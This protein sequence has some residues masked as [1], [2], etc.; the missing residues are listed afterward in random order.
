MA[1][2]FQLGWAPASGTALVDHLA[3]QGFGPGELVAAGLARPRE[4]GG[5]VFDLFRGRLM[6]PIHDPRGHAIGFGA[7]T[8]DPGGIPKYLN[9]PQSPIFDKGH[10]LFGLHRAARAIRAG[11]LAVVVEGYTDVI[12]AHAAGFDNV[13]ASL[14]TALTEHQVKLLK[15]FAG[16][17]VLALDAD[18]AGQAAT[19][20]GLEVAR[21]AAAG[22]VLPVP[23]A[24][25]MVRYEQRL[26]VELRVAALPTGRDPDD[27]IRT[28]PEAWR[29]AVAAA[30]PLMAYLFDALTADLDLADPRGRLKAADRLI[31]VIADIPDVVGRSVWLARL[32]ALIQIDE[33]DL[34]ARLPRVG[35]A[36]SAGGR[37]PADPRRRS[38]AAQ[39]G[40]RSPSSM[41]SRPARMGDDG[42]GRRAGGRRAGLVAPRE[43]GGDSEGGGVRGGHARD[44]AADAD[45]AGLVDGGVGES[46]GVDGGV[47]GDGVDATI[48]GDAD[49]TDV[50]APSPPDWAVEDVPLDLAD[51]GGLPPETSPADEP[52]DRAAARGTAGG[53][54]RARPAPGSPPPA[55][56]P[57]PAPGAPPRDTVP[58]WLLGMLLVDPRRLRAL[59]RSLAAGGQPPLGAEDFGH[60]VEHD[61]LEAV[62][63]ASRGAPPPDAPAE[64]RLDGLPDGHAAHVSALI[65]RVAAEPPTD[66]PRLAE[67]LRATVLR[68]RKRAIERALPGLRFRQAEA[69]RAGEAEL[70]DDLDRQVRLRIEQLAAIT[71][72]LA[73]PLDPDAGKVDAATR[74]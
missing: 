57:L 70:R 68:L 40:A 66:E 37:G 13:V 2:A 48:Y 47:D 7:R 55:G 4:S 36:A 52:A 69:E 18:A 9:S 65:A 17:I 54:V 33:R 56:R 72:L 16:V 64:H 34:A 3:G 74:V 10:Q 30:K 32:A 29:A 41:S 12:R 44:V 25:G 62:R 67:A 11:G 35:G 21:E 51:V 45:P 59:D 6:I 26:D 5:G 50:A 31:P 58:A 22:E 53:G 46:G 38:G 27:V 8:L 60:P 73:P 23:T 61:L 63:Y 19:I 43:A 42:R 71:R 1:Q 14:G 24:S 15:R 39:E 49:G 28:E 20:R